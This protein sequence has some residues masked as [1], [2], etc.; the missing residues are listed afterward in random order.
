E[1]EL[2]FQHVEI[3]VL[4]GMDMRRHESAGRQRRMPRKAMVGAVLRHIGLAE[5][6]PGNSLHALIGA[7]DAGDLAFHRLFSPSRYLDAFSSREP[8]STSPE[9]AFGWFSC[10]VCNP[11][12]NDR[13]NFRKPFVRSRSG[14]C[15][16]RAWRPWSNRSPESDSH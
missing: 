4:I 5:D 2:A 10:P 14:I 8:I 9:N 15:R 3:F 13:R 1:V 16:R 6:I 11:W 12:R 7:G